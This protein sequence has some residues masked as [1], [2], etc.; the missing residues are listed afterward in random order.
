[1]KS[2]ESKSI[3]ILLKQCRAQRVSDVHFTNGLPPMVRIDGE[4]MPLDPIGPM[5]VKQITILVNSMLE[6]IG[7]C[8]EAGVDHDF[9]YITPDSCRHRANVYTQSGFP[10][11]AIRLLNDEIPTID[12]LQLPQLFKDLALQPRGI[13]LV[14]GPTGSGKSTTLAAMIDHININ[15]K[16]HIL[17]FE[18]P[19]EYKHEHKNCIV[20]QREVGKDVE[21]FAPALKS[22]LRED[23]DV[24]LVGEMRDIVTTA[25]AVT[26]AET[27]HF[28]L[29]TLHTTGAAST[30]D[31]II[32]QFP[33]SQQ[34][35]MRILLSQVLRGVISQ[36]LIPKKD[37]S[38]R[39]AAFEIMICNAAISNII[40][41]NKCHQIVNA[42]QTGQAVGM[43][44]LDSHIASLIKQDIIT[45]EAGVEKCVDR[46]MLERYLNR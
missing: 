15:R 8:Y 12:D 45:Y 34:E 5:N 39:V 37:G 11:A 30:L 27:G 24:I 4:I 7:K 3:D 2:A 21:D 17:T 38:G 16:G 10:A 28:V 32:D 33:A 13:L 36:T 18:D 35:Q 22:A 40:R 46:E 20:N 44:T 26:A 29:S 43:Q 6:Q 1:M 25:S 31:R 23:P 41:E 9:C 19:I 42:M 14:T